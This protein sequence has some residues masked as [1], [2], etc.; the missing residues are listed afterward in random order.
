MSELNFEI[1][2][3]NIKMLL[4]KNG[5]TQQDLASVQQ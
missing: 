2:Q 1:L 5:M 4:K 3:E